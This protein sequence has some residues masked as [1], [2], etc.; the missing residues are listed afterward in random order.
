MVGKQMHCMILFIIENAVGIKMIY[1][2]IMDKVK[3]IEETQQ[4]LPGLLLLI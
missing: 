3:A 4:G 1:E 2:G